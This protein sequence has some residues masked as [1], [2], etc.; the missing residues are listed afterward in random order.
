MMVTIGHSTHDF[1]KFVELLRQNEVTAVAD[2]RSTPVSQFAPQF[3]RGALERGLDESGIK[4]VF[5]GE[6][7][8]ARTAD[9]TCYV[10][11]RVQ[12]SR[13]ARTDGFLHGVERL[14]KGARTERIAIMCTEGEPLNCHR[15]VLIAQVLTERG[16]AVAHVH[17]DGW[18]ESHAAAMERLMAK[19]GLA[20]PE[21]F[22]TPAERIEDALSRQEERIAYVKQETRDDRAADA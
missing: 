11:G 6:Y 15:T 17:G 22:R 10:D 8:G 13:L 16:I 18:V 20:E 1:P 5:L 3:N 14:T 7:L 21:L 4:Y 19:F 2:V 9:A 12:Y